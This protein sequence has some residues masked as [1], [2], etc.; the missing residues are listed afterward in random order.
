MSKD[1]DEELFDKYS[2]LVLYANKMK[3]LKNVTKGH[4]QRFINMVLEL[5]KFR[6]KNLDAQIWIYYTLIYFQKN[7]NK[8][9]KA[10]DGPVAL[11]LEQQI[12]EIICSN[13]YNIEYKHPENKNNDNI[14]NNIINKENK[15]KDG[16]S[17]EKNSKDK[18]IE[19]IND[20][21]NTNNKD[22]KSNINNDETENKI[23]K[24][25][26]QLLDKINK[27]NS[28][29]EFLINSI[30][31][32][33]RS[34]KIFCEIFQFLN[35][36]NLTLLSSNTTEGNININIRQKLLN[37]I[38]LIF[39]FISN[40]QK[41]QIMQKMKDQFESDAIAI[42][43]NSKFIDKSK[44]NNI[45]EFL[46]SSIIN[47]KINEFN[48]NFIFKR[49]LFIN[50][51]ND[52]FDLYKIYILIS[53]F[54]FPDY[55][56][57]IYHIAFK[58]KFI[59]DNLASLYHDKIDLEYNEVYNILLRLKKFYINGY[60]NKFGVNDDINN[61][62]NNQEN[63]IDL[64]SID[65]NNSYQEV[66]NKI[67]K[68]YFIR[69]NLDLVS[70]Y[71][72]ELKNF[73]FPF[74]IIALIKIKNELIKN[75]F[76]Q[77]KENLINL[78]KQIYRTGYESLFPNSTANI[79]SIFSSNPRKKII[80]NYEINSY[81]KQVFFSLKT[82]LEKKL[83]KYNFKLY[84]YGSSTEFLSDRDSDID[85]FL[86]ISQIETKK[87]KLDFL[88]NLI[89]FIKFFDKSVNSTISTRVCVITFTYKKIN[90]DMSIVGFCPYLHSVLI[91]EYSLIDPR[92]PLLLIAIK[93]LIKFLRI[94]NISDDRNH[95]FLNSFSWSLLL[96]G[97]L[98]DIVQPPVLPKILSNSEIFMTKA[99]FGNN[100]IE[101][102]EEEKN[103]EKN[104]E[105]KFEKV[106]KLKNFESFINNIQ[107]N[108][109][110]IPLGLGDVKIRKEKYQ[111][112]IKE[113][114]NMT[115]SELLLKFLEFVIFYFKYDTLFIDCSFNHEG[116][117][118]MDAINYFTSDEDSKFL[119]YFKTKYIKRVKEDKGRDG[120]FLLRDPFDSR[121]N[122]GQTLKASSLKKFFSRLKVAYYHLLKY[123]DFNLLKKKIDEEEK[124][125]KNKV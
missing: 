35:N 77:Y 76:Q 112:L 59:L 101:K 75:N 119:H 51:S 46:I 95:S 84:P 64:F 105:N 15:I 69:K 14:N 71:A 30:T 66:Y 7:I 118:S 42:C 108:D 13:P 38:C 86:D 41:L 74:N 21:N 27:N 70:G 33:N 47:K 122:P 114:N 17:K 88:Y 110:Q 53:I 109:V 60:N 107:I 31:K 124:V 23:K 11:K 61:D 52:I 65:E 25:M 121:Y 82:F 57:Y 79:I 48:L 26:N 97:F 81:L 3:S 99:F 39:P 83:S 45:F 115:C 80:S 29:K 5:L 49:K 104:S 19:N 63:A 1:L 113:K 37:L 43:E 9:K 120:Y 24:K 106:N 96:I 50:K 40:K 16:K 22:V 62:N 111:K 93:H 100:K 32:E 116:F 8:Y 85:L 18:N 67:N 10:V 6:G 117:R 72:K 20:S 4:K 91:R 98:Q 89:H 125:I 56:E 87:Q 34:N 28:F 92:F 78:E 90:F 2:N 36:F 58:I 54:E 12:K 55:K 68:F 123:G 44:K 103:S 73:E 94:N 102:E